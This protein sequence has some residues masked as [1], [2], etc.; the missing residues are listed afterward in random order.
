[1]AMVEHIVVA[2]TDDGAGWVVLAFD[3]A[4]E[5]WRER[6]R[7]VEPA[8]AVLAKALA[9]IAPSAPGL[10]PLCG[11]TFTERFVAELRHE[12]GL[13][14]DGRGL[15]LEWQDLARAAPATRVDVLLP[16]GDPTDSAAWTMLARDPF[17][18][19]G[20]HN[21]MHWDGRR[22]AVEMV[23]PKAQ[24][25]CEAPE[26]G[27][28]GRAALLIRPDWSA[29]QIAPVAFG[30]EV[31][32][33]HALVRPRRAKLPSWRDRLGLAGAFTKEKVQAAFRDRARLHHPDGGGD[34]AA[35]RCLVEARD[36]AL[37]ELEGSNP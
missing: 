1:M 33:Y 29:R 17:I 9:L 28:S 18:E 5:A 8:S 10:P 25:W 16:E 34:A 23:L 12:R 36:R 3:G 32:P 35:F 27:R 15:P 11:L 14:R 4:D 26:G 24:A 2:R 19:G 6:W 13:D 22:F 31:P 7:C 20:L 21:A 30:L 37:K